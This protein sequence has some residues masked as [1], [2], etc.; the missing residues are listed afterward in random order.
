V[1]APPRRERAGGFPYRAEDWKTM[2]ASLFSA[3]QLEKLAMGIILLLIVI[4]AAFNIISTLVMVVT[5]KTRR[6]GS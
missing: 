3:L 1:V 6:S 2:N 5:D 4:V